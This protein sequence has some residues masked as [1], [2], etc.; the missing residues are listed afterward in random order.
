M[1][2]QTTE[3]QK[4]KSKQSTT[5]VRIKKTTAR[6]IRQILTKLNK[7]SFG[8]NL[9]TDDLISYAVDLISEKD[10]DILQES[11]LSNKDRLERNYKDFCLKNGNIS[12]DEY[13]GK[14]ITGEI[15][16]PNLVTN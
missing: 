3:N 14:L 2:T 12:K 11:T 9:K 6:K 5:P 10:F 7:K 16:D 13:L 1:E 15:H 4:K 8:R